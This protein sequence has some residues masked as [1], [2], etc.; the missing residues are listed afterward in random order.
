MAGDD[1]AQRALTVEMRA[2]P[3]ETAP[4]VEELRVL[5]DLSRDLLMIAGFDG[6][7][8]H[9]NPA[10]TTMLGHSREEI[11]RAPVIDLVYPDDR[12]VTGTVLA[13]LQ[14]HGRL[15]DFQNRVR[16]KDGSY[17]AISWRATVTD[18]KQRYFAVGR[19][20]TERRDA[21][22]NASLLAA[23]VESS[24]EA[25][26]VQDLGG[27]ITG[28]NPGAERLTGYSAAEALGHPM[29]MLLDTARTSLPPDFRRQLERSHGFDQMDAVLLRKDGSE[30]RVAISVAPLGDGSGHITGAVTMARVWVC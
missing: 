28:W 4:S 21:H 17:R 20:V 7:F 26:I 9:L 16:C 29:S 12:E 3:R 2:I 30:V 25:I 8:R 23:I 27:H 10:W 22:E 11:S 13:R 5:F 18:D 19:D 14:Q 6:L 1:E 15:L 24:S